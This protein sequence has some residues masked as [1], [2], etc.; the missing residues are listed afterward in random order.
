MDS[1]ELG[2][3]S[4]INNLVVEFKQLSLSLSLHTNGWIQ[5]EMEPEL[6]VTG[7]L[8]LFVVCS[9]FDPTLLLLSYRLFFFL[10]CALLGKKKKLFCLAFFKGFGYLFWVKLVD[11]A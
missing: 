6:R 4:Y 2:W 9:N 7:Q 5:A 10:M 3:T 1:R 8:C 11:Y